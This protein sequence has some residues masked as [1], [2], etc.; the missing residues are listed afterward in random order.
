V[1]LFVKENS[2]EGVVQILRAAE[3]GRL[4][5]GISV[6]SLTEIYYIYRQRVG[7]ETALQR[8]EY[9]RDTPYIDKYAVDM[10]TSIQAGIFKAKYKIPIADALVAATA[11][12]ERATIISNDHHF[13]RIKEI[14]VFNETKMYQ[15]MK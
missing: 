1:K 3:E 7:E 10:Q 15:S 12:Q 6:I 11:L 14:Q 9:I 4:K 5:A 8:V 2:W 13:K